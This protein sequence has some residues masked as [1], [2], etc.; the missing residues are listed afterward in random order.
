MEFII[1]KSIT[2]FYFNLPLN[3]ILSSYDWKSNLYNKYIHNSKTYFVKIEKWRE[4]HELIS[5]DIIRKVC[6][7][8]HPNI[9]TY[10]DVLIV[11]RI[12]SKEAILVSICD[13]VMDRNFL[14]YV[15]YLHGNRIEFKDFLNEIIEIFIFLHNNGIVHKDINVSNFGL[16]NREGRHSPILLDFNFYKGSYK[17]LIGTPEF[18][19]PTFDYNYEYNQKNEKRGLAIFIYFLLTFDLPVYN[20]FT[21]KDLRGNCFK[22]NLLK[23]HLLTDYEFELIMKLL[24]NE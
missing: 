21:K 14:E 5:D 8:K 13:F 24:N 4:G 22:I 18:L 6:G 16:I 23:K 20:R 19:D 10:H 2:G 15:T 7:I 12:V 9:L 17:Q 1:E 11:R 3:D